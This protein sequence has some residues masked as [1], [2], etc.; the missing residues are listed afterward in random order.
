MSER[1]MVDRVIQWFSTPHAC[2][3]QIVAR[4][5]SMGKRVDLQAGGSAG[6]ARVRGGKPW[7][8]AV[9]LM[10]SGIRLL[11]IFAECNELLE[12]GI[13]FGLGKVRLR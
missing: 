4:R 8:L 1:F 12:V 10:H 7:Q 3:H 11:R 2:T 13:H 6:C 5:G 9:L